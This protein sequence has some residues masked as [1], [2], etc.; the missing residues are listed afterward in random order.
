MSA[1]AIGEPER[2][3]GYGLAGVA[4]YPA[5]GPQAAVAA[6]DGLPAGV[7]LVVLSARARQAL[8]RRL[9]R[10]GRIWVEIPE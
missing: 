1:A 4:L 3:S 7:T 8:G 9:E 10:P 2:I 5:A 6:W